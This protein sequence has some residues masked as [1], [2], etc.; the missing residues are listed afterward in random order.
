M[1]F[2]MDQY[3]WN[4][5]NIKKRK[6]GTDWFKQKINK[7]KVWIRRRGT[8]YCVRLSVAT[9]W[10]HG[11]RPG[12]LLTRPSSCWSLETITKASPESQAATDC[13]FPILPYTPDHLSHFYW[14][15]GSDPRR[16]FNGKRNSSDVLVTRVILT[17]ILPLAGPNCP[18]DRWR[19]QDCRGLF[20]YI[21]NLQVQIDDF[22]SS[23][24][25][26]L[27]PIYHDVT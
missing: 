20:H 19:G 4:N 23:V 7:K 1:W 3:Y 26:L 17:E 24:F 21:G 8:C 13:P 25:F 22:P 15:I 6:R 18:I 5:W 10:Q 2:Y 27:P 16:C 9:V 12:L 14:M 11:G